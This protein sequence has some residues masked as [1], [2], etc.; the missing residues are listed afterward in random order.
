MKLKIFNIL[1]GKLG[2]KNELLK[3]ELLREESLNS[4]QNFSKIN[5]LI[6]FKKVLLDKIKTEFVSEDINIKY[7]DYYY[8][9]SISRS[10]K[11]MSECRQIRQNLKKTGTSE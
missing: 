6:E 3:F 10:S 11:T 9:N 1:I 5:E 8:S 2:H 7:L 4:I